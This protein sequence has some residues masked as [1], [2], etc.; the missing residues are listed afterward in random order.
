VLVVV[1]G[2]EI[3]AQQHDTAGLRGARRRAGLRESSVAN[4]PLVSVYGVARHCS[5]S[6]CNEVSTITLTYQ[7]SR[8]L[9]WIDDLAYEQDPHAYDL[10]ERHGQ[11]MTVPTGWRLEDRRNRFRM[12]VPNRLAG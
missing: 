7:Y 4:A 2:V 3:G 11:R 5:R 8:A 9:V 1:A 6:S 12:V 10:C